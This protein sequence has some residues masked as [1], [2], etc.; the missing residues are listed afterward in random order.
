[1]ASE[2]STTHN[3]PSSTP[4]AVGHSTDSW[5]SAERIFQRI[6][7]TADEEFARSSNLLG[8]SGLIAGLSMSLSVIG[9]ANLAAVVSGP[10]AD[11]IGALLYPLG[12][13]FVVMGRY[14]LYTENTLT[15]VVRVM[16]RIASI[17]HLLRV[18][19][20]VLIASLVGT[21]LAAFALAKTAIFNDP[22]AEAARDLGH[23]LVAMSGP[24]LFWKGIVAG[25]L[26]ASIVW[27]VH[28]TDNSV[29][30]FLTVFLVTYVLAIADLA[31]CVVGACEVLYLVFT[32]GASWSTF[33]WGFFAPA[34]AGNTVGGVLMVAVLNFA[35]T[36]TADIDCDCR[37]RRLPWDVWLLGPMAR[38]RR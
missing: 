1:M 38:R 26:V 16:T 9:R 14:Q 13:L 28:A 25:W 29:T 37:R 27:L 31:H 34:T 12:F 5:Y 36:S 24:T 7:A 30:R 10:A 4:R 21:G 6:T 11:P 2:P 33:W 32:G 20:V 17:P 15:P 18:W 19:G 22:A 8:V 3:R 23:H 35:R